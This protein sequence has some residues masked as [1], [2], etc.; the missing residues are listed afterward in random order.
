ME[1]IQL[2]KTIF[3]QGKSLLGRK[4]DQMGSHFDSRFLDQICYS[5][6]I[7]IMREAYKGWREVVQVIRAKK[8]MFAMGNP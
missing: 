8:P 1:V 4:W 2:K 5:I 6:G 7:Q 3:G